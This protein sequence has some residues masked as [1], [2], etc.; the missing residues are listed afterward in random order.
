MG[1]WL[2]AMTFKTVERNGVSAAR[3]AGPGERFRFLDLGFL[4]H[5][6]EAAPVIEAHAKGVRTSF[7][8]TRPASAA[9]L[10]VAS[11]AGP[12]NNYPYD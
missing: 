11:L 2:S 5:F 1:P 4:R 7:Q 10:A 3:S 6:Q 8:R 9:E 12:L